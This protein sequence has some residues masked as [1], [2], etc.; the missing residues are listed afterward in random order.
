VI[1]FKALNELSFWK[2]FP[3]LKLK[4]YFWPLSNDLSI[5]AATD[6]SCVGWGSHT[7]GGHS[8][9]AFKI[10]FSA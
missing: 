6:A 4:L 9:I 3:R 1:Y 8:L 5:K 2:D 7:I 10:T